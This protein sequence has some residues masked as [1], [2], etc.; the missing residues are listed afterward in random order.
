MTNSI[1]I[2]E[3]FKATIKYFIKRSE[4]SRVDHIVREL[5]EQCVI[6]EEFGYLIYLETENGNY[7]YNPDMD[8]RV[9]SAVENEIKAQ[10][11]TKYDASELYENC[12]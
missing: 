10:L 7:E 1:E 12:Y 2:T 9:L 11:L 8:E 6:D 3:E 4:T 5:I